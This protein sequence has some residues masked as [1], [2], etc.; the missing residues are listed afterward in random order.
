MPIT[1]TVTVT[2]HMARDVASA[3][4][5]ASSLL[6]SAA[7]G[8]KAGA[9]GTAAVEDPSKASLDHSEWTLS[10]DSSTVIL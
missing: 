4:S 6:A 10:D 9:S 3:T 8:I 1:H 2:R 7:M 5:S